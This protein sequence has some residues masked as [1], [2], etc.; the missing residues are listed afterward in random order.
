MVCIGCDMG[1]T[2]LKMGVVSQEGNLLFQQTVASPGI[3]SPTQLADWLAETLTELHKKIRDQGL[4]LMGVG[5][6]IPG[7]LQFPEGILWDPPNLPLQGKIPL[8][9][10]LKKR[11]P[12]PVILDNDVTMQALGELWQG[13]GVGMD[14][15]ILLSFGTGIGGGIVV[16]GKI[17]RG[18]QGF[19]GELGHITVDRQGRPCRCGSKGCMETYASLNGLAQTLN[20]WKTPIPPDLAAILMEKTYGDIPEFLAKR[21]REGEIQWQVAWD[22][23]ADAL[24]A[25]IGSLIN[26]FNPQR[27]I[28][29]GGLSHYSA[30]FLPRTLETIP[31]Y[32]FKIAWEHCEIRISRLKNKA[33][34]LGAAYQAFHA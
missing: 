1:G 23:F 31:R 5:I 34:I 15:F 29:S 17:Y 16:N 2:F 21:I 27:V 19:A 4:S 33:G 22:I 7:P 32:C 10:L 20:E 9:P 8:G 28:L 25:G 30:F 6:G 26:L 11:L 14:H 13:D 24:G 12:F 3:S 18:A